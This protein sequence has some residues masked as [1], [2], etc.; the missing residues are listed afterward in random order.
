M[1]VLGLGSFLGLVVLHEAYLLVTQTTEMRSILYS[2]WVYDHRLRKFS[3]ITGTVYLVIITLEAFVLAETMSVTDPTQFTSVTSSCVKHVPEHFLV[4]LLVLVTL[5]SVTHLLGVYVRLN[6]GG[7]YGNPADLPKKEEDKGVEGKP[8]GSA[9]TVAL[10]SFVFAC[11]FTGVNLLVSDDTSQRFILAR[12]FLLTGWL[13]LVFVPKPKTITSFFAEVKEVKET[14]NFHWKNDWDLRVLNVI[15]R[16][17]VLVGVVLTL[18]GL[19]ELQENILVLRCHQM[20]W[21]FTG[22]TLLVLQATFHMFAHLSIALYRNPPGASTLPA[23]YT[24]CENCIMRFAATGA[25]TVG[26]LEFSSNTPKGGDP[27]TNFY[28]NLKGKIGQP[29]TCTDSILSDRVQALLPGLNPVEVSKID[30]YGQRVFS[31]EQ[32]WKW[33]W[34]R[35]D[36]MSKALWV[37]RGFF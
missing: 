1:V 5:Y 27:L 21:S 29:K 18:Y 35:P 37:W 6:P 26:V 7:F 4:T 34:K 17:M 16:M 30:E 20:R 9:E 25:V 14:V 13:A 2:K 8:W 31:R 15:L 3:A 22:L 19:I 28:L 36:N 32:F 23:V 33:A 11:V 24:A 12:F 10:L